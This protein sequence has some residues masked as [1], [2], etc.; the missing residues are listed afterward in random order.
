MHEAGRRNSFAELNK[1]VKRSAW[2]H[3][4][5]SFALTCIEYRSFVAAARNL[6]S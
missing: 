3:Q 1:T 6:S 5:S 4:A 2:G